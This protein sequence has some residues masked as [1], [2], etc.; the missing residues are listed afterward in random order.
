MDLRPLLLALALTACAEDPKP[1]WQEPAAGDTDEPAGTGDTDA[2][3]IAPPTGTCVPVTTEVYQDGG[4]DLLG[5]YTFTVNAGDEVTSKV[6]ETFEDGA[7]DR[8]TT[9]TYDHDDASRVI[10]SDLVTVLKDGTVD[11]TSWN[12]YTYDAAGWLVSEQAD[13]D[14]DGAA[15]SETTYTRDAEGDLLTSRFDSLLPRVPDVYAEFDGEGRQLLREESYDGVVDA[16]YVWTY[17]AY[18]NVL[19]YDYE[20]TYYSTIDVDYEYTYD[21][22]GFVVA[23]TMRRDGE[24][25]YTQWW[26]RDASGNPIERTFDVEGDGSI[27]GRDTWTWDAEGRMVEAASDWEP[28]GVVDSVSTWVFDAAGNE[29]SRTDIYT[30]GQVAYLTTWNVYGYRTSYGNDYDLDGRVDHGLS[31]YNWLC[32]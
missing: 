3:A 28:D 11:A 21:A 19:T 14:G 5:L 6:L 17:D 20:S 29:L 30:T 4:G 9:W 27:D 16:L 26:T 31:V 25:E 7:V 22:S 18:G 32:D 8:T 10:R 13:T 2:P 15:D 23:D 12:T 1:E 24:I